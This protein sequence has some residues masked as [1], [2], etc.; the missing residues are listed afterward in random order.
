MMSVKYWKKF[1]D[2]TSSH[3]HSHLHIYYGWRKNNN[4]IYAR[5]HANRIT[6]ETEWDEI[7]NGNFSC[8]KFN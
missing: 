6:S 8:V 4:D 1:K 2:E 5:S 3:T 7:K